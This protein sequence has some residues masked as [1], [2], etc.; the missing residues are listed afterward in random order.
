DYLSQGMDSNRVNRILKKSI[1]LGEE[2][3]IEDAKKSLESLKAIQ[4]KKLEQIAE[5][6]QQQIKQQQEL[7]EKIDNDLKNNIYNNDEFIKGIKVSKAIKDRVYDSITKIVGESP[8]GVA[9]N[10]L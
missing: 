10:K 1:D 2:T 4:T 5:Q 8:T 6:R 7:Q 3:I 9:E